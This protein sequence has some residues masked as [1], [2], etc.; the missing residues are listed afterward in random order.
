M[1]ELAE[2]YPIDGV[3][4]NYIRG[5]AHFESH[6][7]EGKAGIMTE[8]VRKVRDILAVRI[9]DSIARCR[10]LGLDVPSSA[11]AEKANAHHRASLPRTRVL[12]KSPK[13]V[14]QYVVGLL[15][16]SYALKHSGGDSV[17]TFG[18]DRDVTDA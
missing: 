5:G 6:E 16:R 10:K 17:A 1:R 3:E 15:R 9:F 13:K 11:R 14:R 12:G 4:L 2:Q 7:A 18:D 8:F